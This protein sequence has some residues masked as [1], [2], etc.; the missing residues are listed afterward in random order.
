MTPTPFGKLP[1]GRAVTLFTLTGPK[2]LVVEVLDYGA[3]IVAV[4][5]PDRSGRLGDV[6]PGFT[7]LEDY[8]TKSPY[9]GCT[10][11]R[12][13]N[14]IAH[15]KFILNG[16]TYQLATNNVPGGVPCSLHGGDSFGWRAEGR[17]RARRPARSLWDRISSIF[18]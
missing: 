13:G 17:R 8:L 4:R 11:G 16:K 12:V 10:I 5:T 3:T 7:K 9:F 14:R 18:R 1:D 2:G 15:G 6:A